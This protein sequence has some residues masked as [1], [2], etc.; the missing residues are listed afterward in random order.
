MS[1]EESAVSQ[2]RVARRVMPASRRR[3]IDGSTTCSEPRPAAEVLH[4]T[5]RSVTRLPR[6]VNA[7]NFRPCQPSRGRAWVKRS[8]VVVPLPC[9]RLRPPSS[10]PAPAL[11][12]RDRHEHGGERRTEEQGALPGE[13][14]RRPARGGARTPLARSAPAKASGTLIQNASCHPEHGVRAG[15]ARRSCGGLSRCR[16]P[17]RLDEAVRRQERGIGFT[18][19]NPRGDLDLRRTTGSRRRD[20]RSSG[21]AR[22]A[23]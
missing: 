5:P 3:F 11:P 19:G 6:M 16:E 17:R 12:A 15:A 8:C 9:P 2:A 4:L 18:T 23:R 10:S 13:R 14:R 1:V 7:P 22:P 20:R 21:S